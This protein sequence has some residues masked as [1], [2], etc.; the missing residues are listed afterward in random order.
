M[1]RFGCVQYLARS[2]MPASELGFVLGPVSE[3]ELEHAL[4]Q[5]EGLKVLSKIRIMNY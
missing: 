4:A 2:G 5:V 3:K 1:D